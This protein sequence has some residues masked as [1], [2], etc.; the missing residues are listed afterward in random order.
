VQVDFYVKCMGWDRLGHT[1]QNTIIKDILSE[2]HGH[3]EVVLEGS[4]KKSPVEKYEFLVAV[5]AVFDNTK[6]KHVDYKPVLKDDVVVC[7]TLE[8]VAIA[9]FK[10]RVCDHM[11]EPGCACVPCQR[12]HANSI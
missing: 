5:A 10:V 8:Q 2:K 9:S 6:I 7:V 3:R 4:T 12:H 11:R 1:L